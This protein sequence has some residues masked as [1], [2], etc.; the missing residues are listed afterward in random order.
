MTT[1]HESREKLA[2]MLGWRFLTDR[3]HLGQLGL[4]GI[5]PEYEAVESNLQKVPSL[6]Y[7][8]LELSKKFKR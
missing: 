1:N 6:D 8:E 4:F 5:P 7:L 2:Q 3:N